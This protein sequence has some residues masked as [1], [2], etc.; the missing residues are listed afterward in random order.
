MKIDNRIRKM[1]KRLM[2]KK[3]PRWIAVVSGAVFAVS[4]VAYLYC[5]FYGF[6]V[7]LLW[8]STVCTFLSGWITFLICAHNLKDKNPRFAE[9]IK[10][11][12]FLM[13]IINS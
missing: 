1:V 7:T 10:T 8:I 3:I 4:A 2:A 13:M 9:A 12:V 11:F 6:S 5:F